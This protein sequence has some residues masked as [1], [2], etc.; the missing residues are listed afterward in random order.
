MRELRPEEESE[1]AIRSEK[2]REAKTQT[3]SV[4]KGKGSE[5]SNESEREGKG[6]L[7]LSLYVCPMPLRLVPSF[8]LHFASTLYRWCFLSQRKCPH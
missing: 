1:R 3:K 8:W 2:R 6:S 5:A 7:S 4:W